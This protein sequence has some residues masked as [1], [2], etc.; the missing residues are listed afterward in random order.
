VSTA[1]PL[2]PL[3]RTPRRRL[4]QVSTL[5]PVRRTVRGRPA[6]SCGHHRPEGR[7]RVPR[8]LLARLRSG[9]R[10]QGPGDR[11]VPDGPHEEDLTIDILYRPIGYTGEFVI[12]ASL[13][14]LDGKA[15]LER[16]QE[17]ARQQRADGGW[18]VAMEADGQ[19]VD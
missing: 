6:A 13:Q 1:L 15:Q 16:G 12:W 5:P 3:N 18:E 17:L 2:S 14:P 7:R 10:P 4:A 19:R 8:A 9:Q 11:A